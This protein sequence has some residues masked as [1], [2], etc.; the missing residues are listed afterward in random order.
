MFLDTFDESL[1]N[2]VDEDQFRLVEKIGEN[3]NFINLTKSTCWCTLYEIH[4]VENS[5]GSSWRKD[6]KFLRLVLRWLWKKTVINFAFLSALVQAWAAVTCNFWS[7][8]TRQLIYFVQ[9]SFL[10]CRITTKVSL[11]NQFFEV[12]FLLDSLAEL[13]STKFRLNCLV[14]QN[15]RRHMNIN[16]AMITTDAF[17]Q[18]AEGFKIEHMEL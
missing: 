1:G 5:L 16:F 8:L 14:L 11:T 4:A 2:S 12:V 17:T 9:K 18:W 6:N 15:I 13:T 10:E 7:V 3:K